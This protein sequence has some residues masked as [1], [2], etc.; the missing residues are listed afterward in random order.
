MPMKAMFFRLPLFCVL[1]G[2][3]AAYAAEDAP[4]DAYAQAVTAYVTAANEQLV[5]IR[6][7]VDAATKNATE[8]VKRQYAEVY[9]K[10]TQCEE[11]VAQLKI[12]GPADFDPAK[13]KF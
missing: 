10:L 1:L 3:M 11:L 7:E 6:T 5:A 8:R 2:L 4:A 9:R 12:A 13:A